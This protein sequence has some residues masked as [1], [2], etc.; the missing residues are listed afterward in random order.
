MVENDKWIMVGMGCG[1]VRGS[2]SGPLV[3]VQ[4]SSV[5]ASIVLC[6]SYGT[7][8]I[9]ALFM[10]STYITTLFVSIRLDISSCVRNQLN[11]VGQITCSPSHLGS[12]TQNHA[13]QVPMH[14]ALEPHS[15]CIS[16]CTL[17]CVNLI[18]Y[19]NVYPPRI[20]SNIVPSR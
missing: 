12:S 13:W 20:C 4:A 8:L 7:D 10:K 17:Q 2:R 15:L 5:Q 18:V 9:T 19:L 14:L 11:S 6:S 1:N 16:T 3:C